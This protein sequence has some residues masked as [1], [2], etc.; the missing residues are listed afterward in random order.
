M[1]DPG[2]LW[3]FGR[4]G[5]MGVPPANQQHRL[6]AGHPTSEYRVKTEGRGRT[7]DE[8]KLRVDGLDNHWLDCLV[9]CAVAASMQGAT[10]S[11][12]SRSPL[13]D[14]AS[15][16][17]RFKGCGDEGPAVDAEA[18]REAGR[19]AR[20]DLSEVRLRGVPSPIHSCCM[21]KLDHTSPSVQVLRSEAEYG[22]TRSWRSG[23]RIRPGK[24]ARSTQPRYTRRLLMIRSANFRNLASVPRRSR[25]REPCLLEPQSQRQAVC[26]TP[27]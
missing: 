17:R 2:C 25:R 26:A 23:S 14:R 1:G 24:G 20:S 19:A 5:R 9:G 3:L 27:C 13:R 15:A 8:W 12:P 6:L 10:L 22:G 18:H 21:G 7:V 16:C 11:A 4:T